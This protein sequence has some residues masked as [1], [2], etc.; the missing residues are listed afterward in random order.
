[1]AAPVWVWTVRWATLAAA[2]WV[3]ATPVFRF[4]LWRAYRNSWIVASWT[5]TCSDA[6]AIGCCLAILATSP[7]WRRPLLLSPRRAG[8]AAVL[9]IL[10][11]IL[12][13]AA[14]HHF[15]GATIEMF[16]RTVDSVCFAVI[17]WVAL[18]HGGGMFGRVL[19]WKPLTATGVLAYSL[20]LWQQPLL[21]Q[22]ASH[23]MMCRWPQNLFLAVLMAILSYRFIEKPFLRM[24]AR[25]EKRAQP[26]SGSDSA[27]EIH[28]AARSRF[29]PAATENAAA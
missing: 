6:I 16:S 1:M 25:Y 12:N 15:S 29:A 23:L 18:H 8:L 21:N 11:L 17:I 22:Q 24:K 27:G 10:G 4:F 28:V 2:G 14:Y 20:Y 7:E 9:A 3:V 13:Q 19:A 26:R 5:F